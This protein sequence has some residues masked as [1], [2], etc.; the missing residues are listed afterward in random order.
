MWTRSRDDLDH[1]LREEAFYSRPDVDFEYLH[2]ELELPDGLE[3]ND[4]ISRW[5]GE[6]VWHTEPTGRSVIQGDGYSGA[7]R[8][9]LEGWHGPYP[10]ETPDE[11]PIPKQPVARYPSLAQ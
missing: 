9:R 7:E 1:W 11:L 3:D 5:V 4:A 6:T 8:K 10:W 2:H